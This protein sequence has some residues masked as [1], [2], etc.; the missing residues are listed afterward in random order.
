MDA[1]EDKNEPIEDKL[2]GTGS[3]HD[4]AQVWQWKEFGG[5]RKRFFCIWSEGE[6]VGRD[7]VSRGV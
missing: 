1:R 7:A 6:G 4:G 2:E 3:Y 5:E